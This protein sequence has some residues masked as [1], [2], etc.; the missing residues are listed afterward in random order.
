MHGD[1]TSGEADREGKG[2]RARTP[3][4]AYTGKRSDTRDLM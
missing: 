2:A 1:K 3:K 4:E